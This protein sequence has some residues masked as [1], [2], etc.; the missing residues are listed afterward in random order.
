[1]REVRRFTARARRRRRTWIGSIAAV[2]LLAAGTVGAAYSP[3]FEVQKIEVEGTVAV[4][5]AAIEEALS[6]QLG[7]PLPRVDHE[8]I[9]TALLG[10]ARIESYAVEARPPHGL[11]VRIAEREPVAVF[12]TNAGFTTVDAAGVVLSTDGE[13]PEGLPRADVHDGPDSEAFAAVGQ[14][15]RLLPETLVDRIASVSADSAE[16]IEFELSVGDGVRVVWGGPVDTA[17]KVAVLEA[18]MQA[19]PPENTEVYDVSSSGVL[20]VR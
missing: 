8:Q 20:V 18:G 7:R 1:M 13:R 14:V 12:D 15:L 3:L 5:P 6:S 4:D 16:S 17:E 19:N 2:A 10:F 9:R 11:A